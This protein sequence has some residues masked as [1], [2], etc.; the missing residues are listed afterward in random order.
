M[1]SKLLL[2]I[3]FVP[4]PLTAQYYGERVT[5]KSFERSNVYFKSNFLNTFGLFRFQNVAPGLIED[6]FLDL[7][8]N[9]ANLPDFGQKSTII[10]LDF[11]GDRSEAPF[12]VYPVEYD[13]RALDIYSL[14]YIDPRW[15]NQTRTEP[16]P[17]VSFGLLT[18]PFKTSSK[19]FF[20]G[21][22]YQLIHKNEQYYS[23]PTGIYNARAGYDSFGQEVST[24]VPIIDRF[25][26][27]DEMMISGHLF[28]SYVG[29]KLNES[30]DLGMSL[31]SVFHSRDG[32]YLNASQSPYGSTSPSESEYRNL[33]ERDQDY[34]HID[35]SGGVRIH[36]GDESFLGFKVG[37]LSGDARQ[38]FISTDNSEYSYGDVNIPENNSEGLYR[39]STDQTWKQDGNTKYARINFTHQITE[40][41]EFS[42]YFRYAQNNIDLSNSSVIQDTSYYTSH[43]TWDNRESYYLHHSSFSDIRSATGTRDKTRQQGLLSYKWQLTA[44]NSVFAGIYFSRDHLEINSTEPVLA[45]RSSYSENY[46]RPSQPDTTIRTFGL[47]EDKSLFWNYDSRK[48]SFQIPIFV[49]FKMSSNWSVMLGVNRILNSWNIKEE[50]TAIFTRREQEDNGNVRVEKNFGERYSSPRERITEDHTDVLVSFEANVSPDLQI[51]FLL[52]PDFEDEF[53]VA[54][55]WLSFRSSF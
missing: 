55:W 42:G 22:T 46:Y 5:E 21:A 16:E 8:V 34:D 18:Y 32:T 54:Q 13:S 28:S 29:F 27:E 6:P 30:I 38:D 20:L 17:V 11:R 40:D 47:I 10:Y 19:N 50:T 3:L 33:R 43:W 39:S 37:S 44:K 14:P 12:T 35:V 2:F 51:N 7:H 9:P 15:F 24:D 52:N 4:L 49:N 41:K 25:S 26:G 36:L 23:V 31:N 45:S 1:K 53:R 48:W